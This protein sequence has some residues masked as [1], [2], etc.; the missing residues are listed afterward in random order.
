MTL[1]APTIVVPMLTAPLEII[2]L[3][4]LV[5]PLVGDRMDGKLE[6]PRAGV[7]GTE[8]V[9]VAWLLFLIIPSIKSSRFSLSLLGIGFCDGPG[10]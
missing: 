4:L 2:S 8:D 5:L 6:W 3:I 10:L 7:P 1:S 9:G